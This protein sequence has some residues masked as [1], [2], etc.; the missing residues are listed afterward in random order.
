MPKAIGE[1]LAIKLLPESTVT[2]KGIHVVST[3]GPGQRALAR[4][5][6][7][8]VGR[9][10][11]YGVKVGDTVYFREYMGF[12]VDDLTFVWEKDCLIVEGV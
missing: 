8:S 9:D 7:K 6:V 5:V 2:P 3:S 11:K 10:C 12:K 1:K 4:G